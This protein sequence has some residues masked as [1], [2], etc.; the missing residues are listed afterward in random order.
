MGF[1]GLIRFHELDDNSFEK[2]QYG[3]DLRLGCRHEMSVQSNV[4]RLR[5]SA[6]NIQPSGL[7]FCC[8]AGGTRVKW[9]DWMYTIP[10]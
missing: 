4:L 3:P 6:L 2:W 1:L 7:D 9:A 5:H 10:N 8:K